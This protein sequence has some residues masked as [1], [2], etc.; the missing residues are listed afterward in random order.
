MGICEW[1]KITREN[2]KQTDAMKVL[3]E[4]VRGLTVAFYVP[5]HKSIFGNG[6]FEGMFAQQ[7][8]P[9]VHAWDF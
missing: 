9:E 4:H 6:L 3:V 1:V 7:A 2:V 5:C 8:E